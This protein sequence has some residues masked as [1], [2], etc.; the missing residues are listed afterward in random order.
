MKIRVFSVNKLKFLL[1]LVYSFY[2]VMLAY[3]VGNGQ[4][5]LEEIFLNPPDE[6]KPRSYWL[7]AHGNFD[8]SRIKE[9]LK[10]LAEMGLGGADIFDM[11]V[12][13]PYDVI[14]PGNTFMGEEMVDGI[15]FALNE[16]KKLN[17][18]MGLS[19]SNGWNAGGDWTTSEEKLMR[20]LF[21][22]DTI[23]GPVTIDKI[24]FP[25]VPTTFE[26]PYGS[27][28]LFPQFNDE[29][30]PEYY[31]D[32]SLVAFPLSDNNQIG[33]FEQ[34]IYF[35]TEKINGNNVHIELPEGDWILLR[36]VVTPLGQK[37]WLQ[38]DNSNGFIMDH[39]AQKV[40]KRHFEHIINKLE[41][42]MGNMGE[43][44]LERLYLAS[45]EAEDYVIWSP[46]LRQEFYDQ[47]GYQIDP[48]MPAFAGHVINSL[49]YNERFL[50]DYRSTVSEM[51]VNNHYRQA[52]TI[53]R[54]HGL[55]LASESGGPG[56]PLHYVPTEDLKALGSVDIMRGEF[57]NREPEY[58]DENGNDLVQV[59]RN[60]ASAAHIYG[61]KVV[62]MEAFTSHGK[63]WKES[64]IELKRLAD[65]AFCEGMTRVVYHTMTHSPKEAGYPGWS[66][67]AGTHI[68]PKMT[69]WDLSKPFH[70]YLARVSAMLQQG[71][72]VA[73]VAYYYGE[74]IPNF[75][76]GSK[77]IRKS[78]GA[79][80]DY[81]DLN[82]E[83]LL[84]SSV[85]EDGQL[86]LP[87]GM[88]YKILVLPDDPKM[89][90]EVAQKIEKLLADGATILGFKPTTIPGLK[91]FEKREAELKKITDEIWPSKGKKKKRYGKG[92]IYVEYEEKEILREMDVSPDF[93]YSI[94]Y[95]EEAKL[96][97]I[98]RATEKEDIYFIRNEDSV[99]VQAT[100]DFRMN[101]AQPYVYNPENG[102]ITKIGH[103]KNENK[104]IKMPISLEPL[105]SII[106]VFI[107]DQPVSKHVVN[108]EL[109]DNLASTLSSVP[110]V[111]I[112]YDEE[113][114]LVFS[115]EAKGQYNITFSDGSRQAINALPGS[116]IVSLQNSW[117]VR[118]PHGWGFEP[119]QQFDHL[120]D[121]TTHEIDDLAKFSGMATYHSS[122]NIEEDYLKEGSMFI[123]DLGIVGE[124]ARVFINGNEIGTRVFP[125]FDFEVSEF[126][127]EGN[128][129]ISIDVANTWQNRLAGDHALPFDEQRTRSNVGSGNRNS[130]TRP[131]QD[132]D[133]MPSGL[134]GPVRIIEQS[135]VILN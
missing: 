51:F 116:E 68:S 1:R 87:S 39:Y 94:N 97:Y 37:M 88:K 54:E 109:E 57:W 132:N 33:D 105:A 125:P 133:P 41:S 75:A 107:T 92:K 55:L 58:F 102:E 71:L 98:H 60:I 76:S 65:R 96:D 70:E 80:Y 86:L 114:Q 12:A 61:H 5:N 126:L 123:L 21:W 48:F 31:K 45:F 67:Q 72:F 20:L 130:A 110:G 129:F 64:P 7:W 74:Q 115:S 124:V 93:L 8:Y 117:D 24:G 56:P 63:H 40:T 30:F 134:I 18:K 103:F 27:Y 46:E 19:V 4:A 66:Y 127:R 62:E 90:L 15:V 106:V 35:E 85:D 25:E 9:E 17:L 89:S 82:K 83:I 84:Q 112:Y 29:G 34:I 16:A 101:D 23:Q 128:N 73:D 69:W 131:W 10:M 26:K 120:S 14:P 135:K 122:F 49:D 44:A 11:G 36:A 53:C 118:F 3:T 2:F 121:W 100:L 6:A 28:K 59:V 108:V 104:R 119:I 43:S 81:D 113:N 22:K 42:R 95:G 77:Y 50:H 111:D 78:L 47:H 79:G 52:S 13:D 38:S 32:V 91:E 99:Q